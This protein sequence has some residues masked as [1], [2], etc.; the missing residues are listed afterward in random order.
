MHLVHGLVSIP[1]HLPVD[2][3]FFAAQSM[4][5]LDLKNSEAFCWKDAKGSADA[6]AG[7]QHFFDRRPGR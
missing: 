2:A 1:A 3:S 6:L 5:R 4:L 7:I